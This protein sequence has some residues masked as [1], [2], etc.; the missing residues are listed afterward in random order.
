MVFVPR[1]VLPL[2]ADSPGSWNARGCWRISPSACAPSSRGSTC[3]PRGLSARGAGQTKSLFPE[4]EK[5]HLRLCWSVLAPGEL[6]KATRR[7][8]E[9]FRTNH[10]H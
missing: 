1:A 2:R 8:P 5:G 7:K 4:R 10:S 3:P 9:D 6:G